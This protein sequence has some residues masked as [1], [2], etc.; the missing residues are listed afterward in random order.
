M[1]EQLFVEDETPG[2]HELRLTILLRD[3]AK[4]KGRM[5]AALTSGHLTPRLC[6]AL[7]LLLMNRK[8]A[9]LEEVRGSVR[10]LAERMDELERATTDLQVRV[11][12]LQQGND[13]KF[14][15]VTTKQ[16]REF[17]ELSRRLDSI[18]A[19]EGA[20]TAP[21]Q[22]GTGKTWPR[23]SQPRRLFRRTN[24]SV[25]TI[26]P[27]AGDDAAYGVAWPVVQEW[28]DLRLSHPYEGGGVDWLKNKIL[29]R[30]LEIDLIAEHG[31]TLPPDSD[32]WD[33]LERKTQVRCQNQTLNRLRKELLRARIRR[34][35]RRLVF[36][37][38]WRE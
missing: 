20:G 25:D 14:G 19:S 29:L 2:L 27:Q 12:E 34:L 15:S 13:D 26:E 4:Q 32:P 1:E 30:Q 16:A 36:A 35:L 6:D 21:T 23:R 8:F 5:D 38:L 31:S 22:S 17:E 18:E 28:R 11:G 7:E 37:N 33:S 24:P 3:G 9:A 10:E